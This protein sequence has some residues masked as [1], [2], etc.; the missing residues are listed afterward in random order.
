MVQLLLLFAAMTAEEQ[1]VAQPLLDMAQQ[2]LVAFNREV[3]TYQCVI[4]RRERVN[5]RLEARQSV[6]LRV[7]QE[8]F[9]VYLN[10][11]SPAEHAGREILYNPRRYGA[12]IIVK[13][14][15]PRLAFVTTSLAL[16]SALLKSKTNYGPQD[17]GITQL[18]EELILV[19]QE[20]VKHA[21]VH[22]EYFEGA[23]VGDRLAYG[24]RIVN[25]IRRQGLQFYQAVVLI[26]NELQLPVYYQT[27]DWPV[28]P[29]QPALLLEEFTIS[30]LE[31]NVALEERHFHHKY[32]GYGFNKRKEFPYANPSSIRRRGQ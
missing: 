22:V 20:E 1:H 19:L 7:R 28:K 12:Q 5:G 13:N 11:L 30:Q 3:Q 18:L 15:G 21:E 23:K 24:A 17:W 14:G 2:R 27:F 4:H 8:P 29:G 31:F 16:D 9:A 25:P 26:D 6:S 32:E 10:T